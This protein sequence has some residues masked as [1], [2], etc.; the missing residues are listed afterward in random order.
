MAVDTK[1][2]LYAA[3]VFV[4]YFYYGIL[5]E[6]ITRGKYGEGDK[7]E[8]FTYSLALVCSQCII[9]YL[10]ARIMLVTFMKHGEDKTRTIYYASSALTYLLAMVCSNL[11]LQW[12][13]YPTQVVG[14]S[15]KPIPVMVL[16]VLLGGKSYPMIKYLFIL[17]IVLGVGLF[18]Y[19]DNV[20]SNTDPDASGL[21]IGE[22]LLLLS[23]TMDGLT[24]AIQERMKSDHQSKP[25]HM[26]LYMNKWSVGFL[27]FALLATGEIFDF[28]GF[29]QRHPHVIW[30][31]LTFSVASALGQLFI[32]R[33][34]ADYSSLHCTLTTT[35]RKFFTVMASVLYFGNQLTN[36]QWMGAL[37]VF[38]GNN[39]TDDNNNSSI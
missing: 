26:M 32:Y 23:L 39:S 21:G 10:Y 6:R 27:A 22:F 17:T 13:G 9:N 20:A 28:V 35:T 3:G 19:K 7:E 2:L 25:G 18:M 8:K 24:G 38:T 33:M 16:G 29:V 1:F 11:A 31:I 14:K 5:Q 36:R 37:L 12:V 34:L 15:C 30:D 4:C